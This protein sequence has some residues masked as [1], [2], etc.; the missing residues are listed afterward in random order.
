MSFVKRDTMSWWQ[1]LHRGPQIKFP[2]CR[3]GLERRGG[4]W[5]N[6]TRLRA[7]W[8]CRSGCH[9]W[10]IETWWETQHVCIEYE[11]TG[12]GEQQN[13]L[14]FERRCQWMSG[15][16]SATPCSSNG[17]CTCCPKSYAFKNMYCSLQQPQNGCLLNPS[18]ILQ[19]IVF[20][21]SG[22]H[23]ALPEQQATLFCKK[24]SQWSMGDAL[25]TPPSQSPNERLT[26]SPMNHTLKSAC[27][28]PIWTPNSCVLIPPVIP[29]GFVC[30][31][32]WRCWASPEQWTQR[33]FYKRK[34]Q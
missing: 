18:A 6:S 32:S 16:C 31:P 34:Y 4:H 3:T 23:W 15:A 33:L 20:P 17:L 9:V 11:A 2:A 1:M 19:G 29:Q 5:G 24:D 25:G 14:F 10:K 21:S 7:C 26:L 8:H 28:D 27:W 12:P 13:V 30:L 22:W